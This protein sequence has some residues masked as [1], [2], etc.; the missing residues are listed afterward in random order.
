MILGSE[1]ARFHRTKKAVS[2]RESSMLVHLG[3]RKFRA[4]IL[5][6]FRYGI[7]SSCRCRYPPLR[8][9][10]SI[11]MFIISFSLINSGWLHQQLIEQCRGRKGRMLYDRYE[12]IFEGKKNNLKE[13][14]TAV[15]SVF[16]SSSSSPLV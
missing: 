7:V 2:L 8:L 12:S 3:Q 11:I 13:Y 9:P 14:A 1:T 16:S 15:W 5:F 4:A 10:A 6:R